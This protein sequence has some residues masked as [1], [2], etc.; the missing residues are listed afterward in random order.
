MRQF[1]PAPNPN[2]VDARWLVVAR[3]SFGTLAR[4]TNKGIHSKKPIRSEP[5]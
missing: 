3:G 4:L 1:V 2:G 5:I